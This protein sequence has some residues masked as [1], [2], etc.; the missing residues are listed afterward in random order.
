M[1]IASPDDP[2]TCKECQ[3]PMTT[4]TPCFAEDEV[5]AQHKELMKEIQGAKDL[6]KHRSRMLTHNGRL[7]KTI[8]E[9]DQK[10]E[11]TA[12]IGTLALGLAFMFIF[13]SMA[14]NRDNSISLDEMKSVMT[15]LKKMIIDNNIVLKG[16]GLDGDFLESIHPPNSMLFSQALDIEKEIGALREEMTSF[17]E[18]MVENQQILQE[19]TRDVTKDIAKRILFQTNMEGELFNDVYTFAFVSVSILLIFG[20]FVT[21]MIMSNKMDYL[22]HEIEKKNDGVATP[23]V[24]KPHAHRDINAKFMAAVDARDKSIKHLEKVRNEMKALERGSA[25]SIINASE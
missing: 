1:C 19:E 13:H 11:W 2:S 3:Q 21:I 24:K 16:E 4:E 20:A 22:Q 5:V 14:L 8:K 25:E 18:K 23:T 9:I 15:S 17:R 7:S 12:L 10:T 6:M